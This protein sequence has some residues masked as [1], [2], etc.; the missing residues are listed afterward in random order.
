MKLDQLGLEDNG[1]KLGGERNELEKRGLTDEV[2]PGNLGI[3]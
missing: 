2:L 1:L 3:F